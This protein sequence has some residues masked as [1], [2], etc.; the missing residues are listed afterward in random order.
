MRLNILSQQ[1]PGKHNHLWAAIFNLLLLWN[2]WPPTCCFNSLKKWSVMNCDPSTWQCN[3]THCLSVSSISLFGSMNQHFEFTRPTIKR[4]WQWLYVK[5][6][7][8]TN[9]IAITMKHWILCQ[10]RTSALSL[11]AELD[12]VLQW[13]K[14]ATCNMMSCHLVFMI[15]RTILTKH[16]LWPGLCDTG[17]LC[18]T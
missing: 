8:C 15:C 12:D 17:W 9:P 7:E 6:W 3:L 13:S 16:H 10:D 11:L 18:A 4:K 5:G 1:K 14:W 2:W